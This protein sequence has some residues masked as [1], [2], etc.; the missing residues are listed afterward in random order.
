MASS[1]AG[2]LDIITN[3]YDDLMSSLR[4]PTAVVSLNE[5]DNKGSVTL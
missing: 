4:Y 5:N 3:K 2:P 1:S